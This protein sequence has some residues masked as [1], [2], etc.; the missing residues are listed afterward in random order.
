MKEIIEKIDRAGEL[1]WKHFGREITFFLPGMFRYNGISGRYP[2]ISLTGNNCSLDCEHCRGSLLKTMIH[3]E[4]AATLKEKCLKLADRGYH[5][6]LLS[7]GCDSEGCLPWSEFLAVIEEI[8]NKTDLFVSIHSGMVDEGKA[9]ALK[10]AGVDQALIDV[11]GDDETYKQIY[12]VPFG[13]SR[14]YAS[15]EALQKASIPLVPHIVCGLFFGRIKGEKRAIA[16][17]T[18]FDLEQLVIVSYMKLPG[19]GA[20]RF[21]LPV[22]EEV[23]DIIAEARL[24]LPETRMSLGCA[25]QRGNTR[26]EELAIRA[27]INRMALPSDEA[28]SAAERLGMKIKYQRTC[29][30]VS[31]DLSGEQWE[32]A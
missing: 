16:R 17:L 32:T 31:K 19:T 23:A 20:G 13:V 26:L 1:S 15:M 5:G 28:I 24:S 7:G 12:H 9:L 11:I 30:S 2:A 10:R 14:I 18:D 6:V 3:A 27:G 25:R 29:C 8:K 21:R 4:D 22:S